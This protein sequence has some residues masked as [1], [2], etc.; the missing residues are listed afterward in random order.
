M[1]TINGIGTRFIGEYER[2]EFNNYISNKYIV[3]VIPLFPIGSYKILRKEQQ[4]STLIG[5]ST[6]YKYIKVPMAWR[7]IIPFLLTIYLSATFLF[8]L[9]WLAMTTTNQIYAIISIIGIMVFAPFGLIKI[10]YLTQD[11][12]K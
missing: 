11:I 7:H 3:I 1:S 6:K 12:S 2:D 4:N 10:S 5:S 9:L 8:L